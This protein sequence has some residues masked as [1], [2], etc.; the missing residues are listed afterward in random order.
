MRRAKGNFCSWSWK[1]EC[2]PRSRDSGWER[3]EDR[4]EEMEQSTQSLGH[5]RGMDS[6]GE[7][8]VNWKIRG[9]G[10]RGTKPAQRQSQQWC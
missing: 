10:S 9:A 1:L 5:G 8:G 4:R 6:G 3:G 7:I 2:G